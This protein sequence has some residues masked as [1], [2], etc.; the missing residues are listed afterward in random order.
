MDQKLQRHVI[1]S[2]N[3]LK[4]KKNQCF[5]T[6]FLQGQKTDP[7]DQGDPQIFL[8]LAK[9]PPCTGDPG[10]IWAIWIWKEAVVICIL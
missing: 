4:K 3:T 9:C 5:E 1:Y 8:A 2:Y 6:D 7:Q 10:Y